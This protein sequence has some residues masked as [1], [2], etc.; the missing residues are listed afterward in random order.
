MITLGEVLVVVLAAV[1]AVG[2]IVATLYLLWLILRDVK[3]TVGSH[4]AG[5]V[6]RAIPHA[7]R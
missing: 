5:A 1:A 3:E 6:F 2:G 7:K 4:P